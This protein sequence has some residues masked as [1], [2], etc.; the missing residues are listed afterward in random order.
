[1]CKSCGCRRTIVGRQRRKYGAQSTDEMP[2]YLVWRD[3]V[4]R[5]TSPSHRGYKWYGG[6]GIQICEAWRSDFAAFRE[7]VGEPPGPGYSIDRI[8][9]HGHYEPG[10]L[11]WATRIEQARN[12]RSNR[13]LTLG[14]LSLPVSQ[15]AELVGVGQFTIHQRLRKGWPVHRALLEPAVLGKNQRSASPYRT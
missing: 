10:N 14:E 3:I 6:R 8:D 1:M 11:R 15:W 2:L 9:N 5:C 7:Y 4:G 12:T 13:I